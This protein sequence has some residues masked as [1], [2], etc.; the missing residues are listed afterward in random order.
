MP[1][2]QERITRHSHPALRVEHELRYAVAAPLIAGAALWCDLGCG[3][4]VAAAS[5]VAGGEPPHRLVLVDVAEDALEAARRQPGLESA[6]V[7]AADLASEDGVARVRAELLEHA[8]AGTRLITCFEAIEHLASFVP[9]VMLLTDLV[10]EHD[11]TVLLSVPNDAFWAVENPHHRTMWGEGSLDELRS[12]L[13]AD[14]V[15]LRQLP[16][17]GSAIV[18]GDQVRDHQLTASADPG[19][20][21]SHFLVALGPERARAAAGARVVQTDLEEQRRWERQREADL[22][23]LEELRR[24]VKTMSKEF[25]DWRAYIHELEGRLGL[26]LSGVGPGE[27]PPTGSANGASAEA[28]RESRIP[29]E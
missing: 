15:V 16:L 8:P 29:T 21:P 11:F 5:A 10:E 24:E 17:Q 12:L 25:A 19:G 4:G 2:W 9:L 27:E 22:P 14:H 26:P 28:D 3:S 7:V 13:P 20:V 6:V 1:D 18:P 23:Y